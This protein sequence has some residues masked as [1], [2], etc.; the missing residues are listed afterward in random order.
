MSKRKDI[1][2]SSG[3]SQER[4]HI[5]DSKDN[6]QQLIKLL[7]ITTIRQ[8]IQVNK[9]IYLTLSSLG[10][11]QSLQQTCFRKRFLRR[12]LSW[13]AQKDDVGLF[14]WISGNPE[15]NSNVF[16]NHIYRVQLRCIKFGSILVFNRMTSVILNVF[17]EFYTRTNNEYTHRKGYSRRNMLMNPFRYTYGGYL[18]TKSIKL[19]KPDFLYQCMTIFPEWTTYE[20]Y[21]YLLIMCMN[22]NDSKSMKILIECGRDVIS[23]SLLRRCFND[24]CYMNRPN[25]IKV[26]FN[27]GYISESLVD[28]AVLDCVSYKQEYTSLSVL[29][30]LKLGF[31]THSTISF[32][33]YPIHVLKCIVVMLTFLMIGINVAMLSVL[34]QNR[35]PLS[36][37]I[38]LSLVSKSLKKRF[39]GFGF[40]FICIVVTCLLYYGFLYTI[41]GFVNLVKYVWT[42][43]WS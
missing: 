36:N 9:T 7:P 29:I 39:L 37:K 15:Y 25:I 5:T 17:P 33:T 13:I 14:E 41:A 23:R 42:V 8:L 3:A 31:K 27:T 22:E 28:R 6:D 19:Q 12:A 4:L 38:I 32:C 40:G 16:S 35:T 34:C 2:S 20:M 24:A 18:L 21:E 1:R 43:L 10:V 11:V 30:W 26:I